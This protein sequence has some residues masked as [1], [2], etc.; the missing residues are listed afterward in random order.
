MQD[1]SQQTSKIRTREG[2]SGRAL[3]FQNKTPGLKSINC[4]KSEQRL[5]RGSPKSQVWA[6][7]MVWLLFAMSEFVVAVFG[8]WNGLSSLSGWTQTCWVAEVAMTS[9]SPASA[10]HTLA[11]RSCDPFSQSSLHDS[12]VQPDRRITGADFEKENSSVYNASQ[13]DVF[14]FY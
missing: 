13:R 4:K 3:A 14:L 1:C 6:W 11:Y 9:W 8:F 7:L 2:L 10:C 12:D 5:S